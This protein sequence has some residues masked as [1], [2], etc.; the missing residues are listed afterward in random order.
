MTAVIERKHLDIDSTGFLHARIEGDVLIVVRSLI[1]KY[2]NPLFG[3][4][5]NIVGSRE[6]IFR[7]LENIP[8]MIGSKSEVLT[9]H[10]G[11][12]PCR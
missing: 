12:A 11:E 2:H 3:R 7:T 8:S 4:V 6:P 9:Y 1:V 5:L 10:L